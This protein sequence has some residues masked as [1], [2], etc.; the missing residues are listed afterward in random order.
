M[1]KANNPLTVWE[2]YRMLGDKKVL[3]DNYESMQKWM[4]WLYE[5][6]NYETGGALKIRRTRIKR[7]SRFGRLVYATW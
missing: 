2:T 6:S 1:W 5:N 4:T 3:E 7:I